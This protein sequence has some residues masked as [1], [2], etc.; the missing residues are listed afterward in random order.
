[1]KTNEESCSRHECHEHQPKKATPPQS[2][3]VLTKQDLFNKY[4]MQK[5]LNFGNAQ[6]RCY[7]IS[8]V[9]NMLDEY[10]SQ[11]K[12]RAETAE[13]EWEYYYK[14]YKGHVEYLKAKIE[15]QEQQVKELREALEEIHNEG[16]GDVYD[17]DNDHTRYIYNVDQIAGKALEKTQK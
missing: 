17:V 9:I 1:M 11:F 5:P 7:P 15:D 6:E 8:A 10:A 14:L 4:F 13:K 16:N 3:E 12:Q 2:T